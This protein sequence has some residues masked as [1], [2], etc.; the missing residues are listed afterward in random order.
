VIAEGGVVS[1]T[2]EPGSILFASDY[3]SVAHKLLEGT[4]LE[5]RC[6]VVDV[7][8]PNEV[9][10]VLDCG[11]WALEA[12]ACQLLSEYWLWD[13]MPLLVWLRFRPASL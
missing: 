3:V 10:L 11:D 9:W 1:I 7:P 4:S 12:A 8:E 13:W 2:A 5:P 6:V